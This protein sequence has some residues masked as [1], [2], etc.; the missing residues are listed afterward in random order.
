[1]PHSLIAQSK[2]SV[3]NYNYY[4]QPG[5]NLIVPSI[6][7]ETSRHWYSEL[8]YNYE[9]AQTLSAFSGR[10][11]GS[12][13]F[14]I[15][16]MLGVSVGNF[17]GF[18]IAF[19]GDVEWNGF[20]LSSQ[21]QYSIAARKGDPSF[22]FSWTESGYNI[23]KHFFTGP[24]IQFTR[25]LGVNEWQPGWLVGWNKGNVSIPLYVF[26]PFGDDRYFVL[27]INVEFITRKKR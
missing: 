7:I 4:G 25:D 27:G 13:D 23:S 2:W 14:S 1:M 21:T 24:A 11:F 5:N 12:G 15:T 9:A 22:F 19:N 10:T 6:R 18:S 17:T 8:R 26:N 20:Y 3:E 16:P